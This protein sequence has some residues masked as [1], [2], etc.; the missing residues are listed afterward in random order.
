MIT[1][2]IVKMKMDDKT[3]REIGSWEDQTSAD[4]R[5]HTICLEVEMRTSPLLLRVQEPSDLIVDL[6]TANGSSTP[7]SLPNT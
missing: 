1:H 5:V 3:V 6:Y 4:T 2:S 7:I